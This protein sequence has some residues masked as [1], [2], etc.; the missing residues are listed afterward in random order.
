MT[1]NEKLIDIFGKD[2][3]DIWRMAPEELDNFMSLEYYEKDLTKKYLD[4]YI[5]MCHK[6]RN[7][8]DD[9]LRYIKNTKPVVIG[10][11]ESN[12]TII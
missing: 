1:N 5:E 2:F 8:I 11:S 6:Q 3:N 4:F 9:L 10:M 12:G 7:L